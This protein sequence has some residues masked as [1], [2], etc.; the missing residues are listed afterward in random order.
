MGGCMHQHAGT[1][2]SPFPQC[3]RGSRT[4]LRRALLLALPLTALLAHDARAQSQCQSL[5]LA[6]ASEAARRKAVCAARAAAA[7]TA[8][9]ARCLA[10]AD[11]R[12]GTRAR[13]WR[14]SDRGRRR[15]G[16]DDRRRLRRDLDPGAHR[17]AVA[18]LRHRGA[19]LGEP[20]DR[21]VVVRAR[22]LRNA[23]RSGKRL[24]RCHGRLRTG[25]GHRR[26]VLRPG[27]RLLRRVAGRRPGDLR[28]RR[29]HLPRDRRVRSRR[30]LQHALRPTPAAH[31]A[32]R[33]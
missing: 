17:T 14:L 22:D 10:L 7:G 26:P 13:A 24:G 28:R 15:R 18:L 23:R 30:L 19:L 5:Q 16:K 32:G 6:A 25:T 29:R 21:R 1:S 9:D 27:R 20:D 2:P 3:A 33:G 31:R 4:A 11:A 8:V 12:L